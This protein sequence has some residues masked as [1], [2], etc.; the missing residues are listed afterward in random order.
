MKKWVY[1]R[2]YG[3]SKDSNGLFIGVTNYKRKI[4]GYYR[5][6]EEAFEKIKTALKPNEQLN[7]V[8]RESHGMF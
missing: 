6:S 3:I 7:Y 2:P 8:Y 1:T 5:N 4:L